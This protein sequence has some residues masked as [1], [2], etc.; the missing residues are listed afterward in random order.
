MNRKKSHFYSNSKKIDWRRL[1]HHN[2]LG[3]LPIYTF[4]RFIYC[5]AFLK[6]LFTISKVS[7][8]KIQCNLVNACLN[9]VWQQ[10]LTKEIKPRSTDDFTT[11]RDTNE[12][13]SSKNCL[14]RNL[15]TNSGTSINDLIR[16]GKGTLTSGRGVKN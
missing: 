15:T 8:S 12:G 1:C 16:L 14:R 6:S 10:N 4:L 9:G 7:S 11:Q 5:D 13:V 2:N 3:L